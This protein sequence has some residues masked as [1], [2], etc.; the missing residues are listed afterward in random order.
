MLVLLVIFMVTAPILQQ[1]VAVNLPKVRAAALAGEEQQLVVAVDPKGQVYLNDTAIK[2]ADLGTKLQA[3]LKERPDRQVF[4]R[5]DQN[6][7]YGA[8]AHVIATIKGA[9]VER[10]G[11]VTEPPTE[12]K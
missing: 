3:I 12:S 2:E 6:V 10:L 1:G 11:M 4:L 9:G 8:V 5:A 7:R